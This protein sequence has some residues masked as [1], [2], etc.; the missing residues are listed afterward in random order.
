MPLPDKKPFERRDQY[1][2]RCIPVEIQAGKTRAQA[3]AICNA[4]FGGHLPGEKKK[5]K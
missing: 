1:L 5:D 3:A 4:N 2:K